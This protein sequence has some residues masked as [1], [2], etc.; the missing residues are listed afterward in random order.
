MLEF[1][2]N[3]WD[4]LISCDP[5]G[6]DS[7]VNTYR[8]TSENQSH[9][10]QADIGFFLICSLNIWFDIYDSNYIVESTDKHICI[11]SLTL[12]F[13]Q[14]YNFITYKHALCHLL[15]SCSW[16][17]G[18]HGIIFCQWL[19]CRLRIM[20]RHHVAWKECRASHEYD[21]T[22]EIRGRLTIYMLNCFE[23]TYYIYIYIIS[24]L[25]IKMLQAVAIFSHGRRGPLGPS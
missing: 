9:F 4:K 1:W 18:I 20:A 7:W 21:M 6:R 17:Q 14:V 13:S 25:H 16:I 10:R 3:C 8:H 11:P 12:D 22:I 5:S 24:F 2:K 23:E 19:R 15:S